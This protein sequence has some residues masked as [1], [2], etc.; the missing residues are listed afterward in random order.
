[1]FS[2]LQ[3]NAFCRAAS[4]ILIVMTFGR[5]IPPAQ[6]LSSSTSNT[7]S[8]PANL[9][10]Q[11]RELNSFLAESDYL[12][13]MPAQTDFIPLP[14]GQPYSCPA[15]TGSWWPRSEINLRSTCPWIWEE[16]DNG[17]DAYPRHIR[18]A[19]CICQSCIDSTAN[20]CQEIRQD[21][22]IFR[23]KGCQDGLV[24]L[25]KS[26]VTVTL[27]CFCV[28]MAPPEDTTDFPIIG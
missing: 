11:V 16:L 22:T 13:V 3:K 26:E 2:P 28:A 5:M 17:P 7:C 1:M 12:G 6:S 10:A 21:V 23:L 18:Q 20:V 4:A 27:A 8:L 24:V 9:P 14:T 25:Q 15:A 19:K